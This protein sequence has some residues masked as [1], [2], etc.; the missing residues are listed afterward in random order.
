MAV[1]KSQSHPAQFVPDDRQREAI[2]HVHGPMLVVAGAGTGK[3]SVLIH[4][5]ARL[6]E[7]GHAKPEEVLALTYTVA[8]AGEMRDRVRALLGKPIHSATFHDYCLDLLKRSGKDFGVL[9]EKDLWIYLRKRIHELHLEH[10]VRAANVGQFL[11]DLLGFLSRCHDE[12]VTPEKYAE[13]VARL[14]R[15][16]TPVPRVAKSKDQLSDAEVIARCQEIARVFATTENWLREENLGTFGHMI[17]RARELLASDENLLAAE[18]T[19]ARFILVDEFQDAN[20]AQIKVLAALAGAEANVFGV[21]D[22]DQA[23]YR[24]RGASSAAFHLFRRHFPQTKLVVLGKNRRSTTPILQCAFAV[25]DKNP[26]CLARA[27]HLP[28]G[29]LLCSRRAKKKRGKKEKRWP[30]FP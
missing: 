22:P 2:E 13:Y 17:T 8:A 25:V 20:F 6:V 26:P 27:M 14:E 15:G 1:S 4:R 9:D 3:T 12:L 30:L 16:E 19:R 11:N 10:Y 5:I 28:T 7:Q 23:I 29:G 21:G 24:F 18:R